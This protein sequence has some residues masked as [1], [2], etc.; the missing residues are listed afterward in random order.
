[1]AATAAL[2]LILPILGFAFVVWLLQGECGLVRN[3]GEFIHDS[4]SPFF[5][6]LTM[7]G[8]KVN[9]DD[10]AKLYKRVPTDVI[11]LPSKGEREV[12]RLKH[13]PKEPIKIRLVQ[14][15]RL[16]P[17][18]ARSQTYTYFL[19]MAILICFGSYV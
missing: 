7:R 6:S 15:K 19:L 10:H 11:E 14:N 12:M 3:T 2:F 5:T 8:F 18:R 16:S 13:H 4:V 9:E 1:M 17:G